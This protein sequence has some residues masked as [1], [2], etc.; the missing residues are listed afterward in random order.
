MAD[1]VINDACTGAIQQDHLGAHREDVI[2]AGRHLFMDE[3]P[4]PKS[5]CLY[6]GVVPPQKL[7]QLRRRGRG[8]HVAIGGSTDSAPAASAGGLG[9]TESTGHASTLVDNLP[10]SIYFSRNT[11]S[12]MTPR[13]TSTRND[14]LLA[15]TL[16]MLILRML[17]FGPAHGHQIATTIERTSDAVLRVDHGSLYP[18][19]HRLMKDG[20]ITAEWGTSDNNRRA[21]FYALTAD[22]RDELSHESTRWAR[23]VEAVTRVMS[24]PLTP[25]E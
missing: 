18:A 25:R 19:L 5:Q 21:K 24:Q 11:T 20:L 2:V 23:M 12:A 15:G 8:S 13:S 4:E 9:W 7:E 1:A 3:R 17:I 14:N 6:G 10:D 22:G 16:D